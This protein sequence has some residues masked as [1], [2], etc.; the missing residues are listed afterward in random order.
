MRWLDKQGARSE[1][2]GN[3][4][5]FLAK[6]DQGVLKWHGHIEMVKEK[7]YTSSVESVKGMERWGQ[8]STE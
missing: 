1:M 8:G 5:S 4:H 3:W 2:C 7:I 6:A